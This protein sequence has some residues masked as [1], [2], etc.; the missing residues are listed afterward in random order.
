MAGRYGVGGIGVGPG[1]VPLGALG[2]TSKQDLG[3]V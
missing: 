1:G 2:V 3:R